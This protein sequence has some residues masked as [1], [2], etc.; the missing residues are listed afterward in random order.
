MFSKASAQAL[1]EYKPPET[2]KVGEIPKAT[3]ISTAKPTETAKIL[4]KRNAPA[5]LKVTEFKPPKPVETPPLRAPKPSKVALDVREKA[6]ETKLNDTFGDLAQ[7]EPTTI[8]RQVR[9]ATKL[10]KDQERVNRILSGEEPLPN[11]LLGG[12]LIRAVEEHAKATGDF[13]LFQK[14]ARSKITGETSVHAQE[15]RMLAERDKS[16]ALARIDELK[17]SRQKRLATKSE[18]KRVQKE[19]QK[20]VEKSKPTKET[21]MLYKM[22][23]KDMKQKFNAVMF[24]ESLL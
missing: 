2:V 22:R 7:Y 10:M 17:K 16:S 11:G 24:P 15:L 20:V 21:W 6:L 5:E 23:L 12:T 9:A 18:V 8:K 13:E 19:I 3:K 1:N 4:T 14:L